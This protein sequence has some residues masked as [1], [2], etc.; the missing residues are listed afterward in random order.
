MA[1]LQLSPFPKR[2]QEAGV[3]KFKRDAERVTKSYVFIL[4][5]LLMLASCAGSGDPPQ[6]TPLGHLE[7]ILSTQQVAQVRSTFLDFSPELFDQGANPMDPATFIPGKFSPALFLG[8]TIPGAYVRTPLGLNVNLNGFDGPNQ[9][10]LLPAS[11][12]YFDR[13][14]NAYSISLGQYD[15]VPLYNLENRMQLALT[16]NPPILTVDRRRLRIDP[17]E[18][19]RIMF[20][21]KDS[22]A[23]RF[24]QAMN[25][26]LARCDIIIEPTIFY[27]TGTNL[28]NTWAGGA[29]EEL[30]NGR[31]RIRVAVFYINGQRRVADWR[32]FLVH[33]A[34]NFLVLAIGR[35]DLAQ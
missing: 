3:S 11:G 27:I 29:I 21:V 18:I 10:M 14:L 4:V 16:P 8:P 23:M 25:V 34:I 31:Y 30:G 32:E 6:H 22:V 19:D 13:Q 12:T 1:F 35:G 24:P 33:E 20:T 9:P 26:D 15:L 7:P 2:L 28:G 5:T 17:T